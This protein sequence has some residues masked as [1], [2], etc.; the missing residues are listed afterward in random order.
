LHRC[1]FTPARLGGHPIPFFLIY[2][3]FF[4]FPPG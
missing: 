2:T 3:F 1:P 4:T